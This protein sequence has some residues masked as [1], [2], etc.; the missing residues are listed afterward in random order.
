MVFV[1]LMAGGKSGEG[2]FMKCENCMKF[3]FHCPL[4][5]F[6]ETQPC[7]FINIL[8]VAAFVLQ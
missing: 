1:F 5:S 2:Y 4:K 6:I 7:L 8:S 3:K